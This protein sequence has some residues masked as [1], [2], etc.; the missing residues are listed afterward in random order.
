M[1][2]P[3]ICCKIIHLLDKTRSHRRGI[4]ASCI[5]VCQCAIQRFLHSHNGPCILFPISKISKNARWNNILTDRA[6]KNLWLTLQQL[7]T[8]CSKT[9]LV[10]LLIRSILHGKNY[11]SALALMQFLKHKIDVLIEQQGMFRFN[12]TFACYTN[13]N[14]VKNV[15]E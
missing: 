12:Y 13:T 1:N 5:N 11:T 7:F 9:C 4:N 14:I 2:L 8:F 10:A 3:H 6:W 15:D